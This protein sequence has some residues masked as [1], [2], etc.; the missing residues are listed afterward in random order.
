MD[1]DFLV[2]IGLIISAI[3]IP[4]LFVGLIMLLVK[5]IGKKSKKSS[6]TVIIISVFLILCGIILSSIDTEV[7]E[8]T[9][10]IETKDPVEEA[11]EKLHDAYYAGDYNTVYATLAY[12]NMSITIDTNPF[13]SSRNSYE[14]EAISAVLSINAYLNFPSS[15]NERISSTRAI[16]G[17]QTQTYGDYTVSW[18]YH[19]DNGLKII[20][21]V[22]P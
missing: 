17:M 9:D 14:S 16:D 2:S 1:L 10:D 13:D 6:F 7:S 20:Y 4:M 18:T 15:L 8:P 21:E 3:G 11:K 22:T 5:A 12:D 19:P